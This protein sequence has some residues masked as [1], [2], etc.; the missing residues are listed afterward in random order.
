MCYYYLNDRPNTDD[1]SCTILCCQR[2]HQATAQYSPG[3]NC[4]GLGYFASKVKLGGGVMINGERWIFMV[5]NEDG[6]LGQGA[7]NKSGQIEQDKTFYLRYYS[8]IWEACLYKDCNLLDWL[9]FL[10]SISPKNSIFS[11]NSCTSQSTQ[12]SKI[13][14]YYSYGTK[15][16]KG[17]DMS[18]SL[19]K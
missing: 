7:A 10:K 12:K 18:K 19:S 4:R 8:D 9:L 15:N 1:N 6:E 5:K 3:C 13:T 16:S 11:L 14:P 2:T 17:L